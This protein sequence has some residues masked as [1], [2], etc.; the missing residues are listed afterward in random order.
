MKTF[1]LSKNTPN[2]SIPAII[3]TNNIV[4]INPAIST[5]VVQNVVGG[6][7]L[8]DVVISLTRGGPTLTT[9]S[10]SSFISYTYFDMEKAGFASAIGVF[11]FAFIFVISSIMNKYFRSKEVNY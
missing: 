6:L 4:A 11:L 10:I 1:F 5:A 8:N 3:A 9:H 2:S 7:K